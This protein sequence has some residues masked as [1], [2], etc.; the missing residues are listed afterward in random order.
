MVLTLSRVDCRG[1]IRMIVAG[2]AW[3]L[4]LSTGFFI[5][6]LWQC[7]LP[8]PDDIAVVTTACIGTGILTIGPLAAF[9]AHAGPQ[10]DE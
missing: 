6:A 9:A 1:P 8:C 3:G 2:A 5:V 4:T 7:G 10:K